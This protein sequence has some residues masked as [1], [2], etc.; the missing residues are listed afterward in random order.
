MS[1]IM[2][3]LN[4]NKKFRPQIIGQKILT[5]RIIS[6]FWGPSSNFGW[7]RRGVIF[8]VLGVVAFSVMHIWKSASWKIHLNQT[9]PAAE[10]VETATQ[11]PML[12][13]A[14]AAQVVEIKNHLF[15]P[16]GLKLEGIILDNQKPMSIINGQILSVGDR[17]KD[18]EVTVIDE[19]GV[20]LMDTMGKVTFLKNKI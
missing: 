8:L 17:L 14:L 15:S 11:P 4:R 2:D 10:T 18:Q 12:L 13:S 6:S 19:R 9:Q 20:Y 16:R 3:V 7:V 5:Q 1:L